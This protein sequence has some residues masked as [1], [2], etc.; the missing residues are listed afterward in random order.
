MEISI[1]FMRKFCVSCIERNIL[2]KVKRTKRLEIMGG[3]SF[4]FYLSAG[5]AADDEYCLLHVR[6]LRGILI[7]P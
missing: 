4:R 2:Q 7:D 3:L 1:G 6:C 5:A